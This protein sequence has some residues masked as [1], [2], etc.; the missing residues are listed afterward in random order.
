MIIDIKKNENNETEIDFY[1]NEIE[2]LAVNI[3]NEDDNVQHQ[4]FEIDQELYEYIIN[5]FVNGNNEE[6][7]DDNFYISPN[8]INTVNI[9]H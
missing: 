6:I 5:N 2:W 4:V 7:N 1:E 9:S 8:L 3:Y